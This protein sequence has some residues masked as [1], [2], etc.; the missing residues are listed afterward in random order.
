MKD[1][2]FELERSKD[3]IHFLQM[4]NK[5]MSG[6]LAIYETKAVKYQ[7]EA[8]KVTSKVGGVHGNL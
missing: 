7:K 8:Q 1:L 4:K 6:Y 3:V 5:Q 2:E